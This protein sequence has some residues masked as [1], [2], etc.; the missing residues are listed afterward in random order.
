MGEITIAVEEAYG[1][2]V[3]TAVR[4]FLYIIAGEHAEAAGVDFEAVAQAVFHREIRYRRDV[5]AHGLLHVFF[6]VGI[7]A[8]EFG[9]ECFI[10]GEFGDT[11]G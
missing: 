4:R 8:V 5:F 9:H 7:Y 10:G 3:N 1:S 6:E 2:H 11:F